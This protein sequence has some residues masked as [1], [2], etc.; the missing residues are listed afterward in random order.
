V[1]LLQDAA[2]NDSLPHLSKIDVPMLIVAGEKDGFTP[3]WLSAI[4]QSRVRD[5][6]LCTVP[7]GT[8][9]APIEMPELVNL[10][11][12]RFLDERVM[13]LLSQS[14]RSEELVAVVG[15]SAA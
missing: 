1:R 14:A 10:R 8:H 12:K 13:P 15:A 7:M 11:L 5:S 4:M 2:T 3:S 9:T 6:E